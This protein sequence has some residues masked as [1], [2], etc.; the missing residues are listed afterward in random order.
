[1]GS[2]PRISCTLTGLLVEA[3]LIEVD[4]ETRRSLIRERETAALSA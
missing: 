4:L 1:M 2:H 3:R